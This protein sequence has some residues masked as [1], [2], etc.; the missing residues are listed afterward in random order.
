[1]VCIQWVM[2]G[3]GSEVVSQGLSSDALNIHQRRL[4]FLDCFICCSNTVGCSQGSAAGSGEDEASEHV[5]F[6][7]E[8][9]CQSDWKPLCLYSLQQLHVQ[10]EE[11]HS[12][13]DRC[14]TAAVQRIQGKPVSYGSIT[15]RR[16][17]VSWAKF[18]IA[19]QSFRISD[20]LCLCSNA[21]E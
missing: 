20:G 11:K 2:C 5:M 16:T 19:V 15:L 18:Y 7:S 14:Q 10:F 8:A 4:K 13:S 1:M 6:P 3:F 21:S 9:F 17:L 12:P